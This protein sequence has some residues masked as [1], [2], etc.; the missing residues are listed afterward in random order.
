MRFIVGID[1]GGTN[2]VSGCVAEDGSALLGAR[3]E[4]TGAEEGPDAVVKRIIRSAQASIAATRAEVPTAEIIGAGIGS[5][6][7]LDTRTGI[8]LLTPNL[9]WVN[10]PLRARLQEGL[11]LRTALDNDANCAVLG[12]WWMGAARGTRQALGLTIGT[13]IGGGIIIDGRLYHGAS[14]IAGE[15]GHMTIDANGRRCKCG[16]YGCLEAYASGPAIAQRAREA[17]AGGEP[18]TMPGLVEGDLTLLTAATVF[19]AAQ[20]GDE[21]AGH[22]VRD[23]AKFLGIGVANFLNIF[24]PEV[25]VIAG[26]VTQAGEALFEPLRAEVRRRAFAPAVESCRIV[27]GELHGN[28]GVVGAVAIFAQARG[29]A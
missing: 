25:V 29:L 24:N 14:D 13:G 28:A 1:L 6:G 4:P 22:V 10:M 12:E 5:P 8:V 21:L 20:G 2:I 19:D 26:G 15:I 16:N 23:T 3:S 9:G 18:S 11:G 27:P 7:P 17:L